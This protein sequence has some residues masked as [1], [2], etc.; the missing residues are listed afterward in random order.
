MS[1]FAV[2]FRTVFL[3]TVVV[4]MLFTTVALQVKGITVVVD[5]Q[6]ATTN[7]LGTT[8]L[9]NHEPIG[10]TFTPTQSSVVGFSIYIS[11]GNGVPTPM[12]AKILSGGIGGSLVG[13]KNFSIPEAFGSPNGA[14]FSVSFPSGVPVT[15]GHTY[16]IDLTDN[17]ASAGIRLYQCTDTYSGGNGYSEGSLGISSYTFTES[18]GTFSVGV[19]PP[20]LTIV[21]GLS[22]N[23]TVTIS[24]LS[25]FTSPV[26]LNASA[27]PAGV[28][29]VFGS[30]TLT[31]PA[32][33]LI[34]T[35]LTVM[36]SGGAAIGSYGIT[37]TATSGAMSP[38]AVLN[39]TI[40]TAATT[41]LMTT[42]TTSNMTTSMTPVADFAITSSVSSVSVA[43]G[44]NG[45]ATIVVVSINGFN[46]PVSLSASWVG[47]APAGV[48]ATVTS[49]VVPVSGSAASSPL[50]I[51]ATPGAS[52]GNFTVRIIGTSGMLTHTVTPDITVQ[53]LTATTTTSAAMSSTTSALPVTPPPSCAV[54]IATFGS[55]IAPLVQGLRTFR[56]QSIMKTHSGTA[57]M[58]LFNAWYYSFSPNVARYVS[59]HPIDRTVLKYGLYPLV[60]ILYASYYSYLL[61]ST[62]SSE[63]GVI[64]A[65]IVAAILM[66]L[67]YLAPI[68]FLVNRILRRH[69]GPM[70]LSRMLVVGWV[71]V[72]VVMFA[73][74]YFTSS[75]LI[76]GIGT[77][78]LALGMLSLGCVLGT[79]VLAFPKLVNPFLRIR[80]YAVGWFIG[81]R[82]R[83]FRNN[84]V[85][86]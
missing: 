40:T 56:D 4:L 52:S 14:W 38:N 69:G 11:S 50:T 48:S 67:V 18:A 47:A 85:K 77:A 64:V 71:G 16:A 8:T 28:S 53:V 15:P 3:L 59:A 37:I 33:G 84:Y 61:V 2:K 39:L 21:Q 22:Q 42:S 23:S 49:P 65:G 79:Q 29:V 26:Q 19:S 31:P 82:Y 58:T 70:G 75:S 68:G 43:P 86:N 81:E 78:N 57:F 72:S 74:S 10:Q 66:G 51:T 41:T 32:N 17:L 60:G 36:V 73:A 20:A 55:E 83:R 25:N 7:G 30:N 9:G 6:C 34:T 35:P 54:A 24:S 13:S 12:T 1:N 44:G 27:V 45:A 80:T 62:I 46:S 63:G 5:Q 76:L